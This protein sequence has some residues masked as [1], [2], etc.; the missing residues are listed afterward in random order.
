MEIKLKVTEKRFK[1]N[2]EELV[3]LERL[4]SREK[5]RFGRFS[6]ITEIFDPK[7]ENFMVNHFKR[8]NET[9]CALSHTNTFRNISCVAEV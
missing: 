6:E 7:G 1:K 5:L 8:R 3:K 9:I 4:Q 2:K